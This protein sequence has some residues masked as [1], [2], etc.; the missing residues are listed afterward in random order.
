[1]R[2]REMQARKSLKLS[3][4]QAAAML[5]VGVPPIVRHVCSDHMC[6]FVYM[7]IYILAIGYVSECVYTHERIHLI[8][9]MTEFL[10]ANNIKRHRDPC[11]SLCTHVEMGCYNHVWELAQFQ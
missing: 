5:C 4:L 11:S 8:D 2:L 6:M 3:K 1:M 7:Y 9:Y 10:A